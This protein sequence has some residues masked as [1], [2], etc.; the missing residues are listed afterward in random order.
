MRSRCCPC[1]CFCLSVYR[2]LSLLGN[3][4]VFYAVRV[5]SKESRRLDLHRT[6]CLLVILRFYQY[7]DYIELNDKM[8]EELSIENDLGGCCRALNEVLS[9]K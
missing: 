9:S 5:V 6:S 2:P 3:G 8:T 4:Y 1:V 7:L